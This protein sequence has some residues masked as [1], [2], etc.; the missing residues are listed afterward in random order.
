MNIT[1][2]SYEEHMDLM[3][4]EGGRF[5]GEYQI[6]FWNIGTSRLAVYRMADGIGVGVR[7]IDGE[8][9]TDDTIAIVN[10]YKDIVARFRSSFVCTK[11]DT[12]VPVRE[13]GFFDKIK[14][15]ILSLITAC[16]GNLGWN[17]DIDDEETLDSLEQ[18]MVELDADYIGMFS[19]K[20]ADGKSFDSVIYQLPDGREAIIRDDNG[21][22][23]IEYVAGAADMFL[24]IV[25]SIED[26]VFIDDDEDAPEEWVDVEAMLN[27][28]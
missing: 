25:E 13:T 9:V 1:E 23:S 12:D 19:T 21:E 16:V 10:L 5:I 26:P 24:A 3:E 20:D 8:V 17:S 6:E 15:T 22:V 27:D 14:D 18:Y 11:V 7:D 4:K 28:N 2:V